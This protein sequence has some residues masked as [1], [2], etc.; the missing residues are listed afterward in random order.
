MSLIPRPFISRDTEAAAN[1]LNNSKHSLFHEFQLN[2]F[3]LVFILFL[4]KGKRYSHSH[5]HLLSLPCLLFL[6]SSRHRET[7]LQA[8]TTEKLWLDFPLR[9]L[10]G[11]TQ[12]GSGTHPASL[13]WVQPSVRE[14]IHLHFSVEIKNE[15]MCSRY[16]LIHRPY[17]LLCILYNV[18]IK[19]LH[20]TWPVLLVTFRVLITAN[21]SESVSRLHLRCRGD[22]VLV[23]SRRQFF[24]SVELRVP[25][26]RRISVQ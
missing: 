10:F 11:S 16:S 24:C 17:L 1:N 20:L 7:R 23:C 6:Y 22:F 26:E 5:L 2:V 25:L 21:C 9:K 13:H 8:W 4:P 12:I 3:V 15:C 14:G 19:S 18:Q